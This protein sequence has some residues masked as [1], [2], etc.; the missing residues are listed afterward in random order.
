MRKTLR[1]ISKRPDGVKPAR[2]QNFI[3]IS[4]SYTNRILPSRDLRPM[5]A[6]SCRSDWWAM[7]R[8]RLND[9][10]KEAMK[11]KDQRR[12]SALRMI[13]AKLKDLDIAARTAE[14]REGIGEGA[15][16]QALTAMVKQRRES[17][18][19]YKQGGR[20]DLVAQEEGEI[21]VIESF[22]PRQLDE[23]EIAAA[24]AEAIAAVE[25]K[26]VKDMGRVMAALKA[27]YAG[28]MDFA[29]AGAV[30]KQLLA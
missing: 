18:A 29:K 11:A 28:Q 8:E 27:R 12:V 23:T 6:V 24:A 7:L 25:A 5:I 1:N 4:N 16:L 14:S 17:I 26:S 15:I 13:L 30:V 21:A 9:A 22:M 10:L 2:P 20:A 19:L 3:A